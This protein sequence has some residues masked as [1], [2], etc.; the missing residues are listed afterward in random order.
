MQIDPIRGPVGESSVLHEDPR[1][2]DTPGESYTITGDGDLVYVQ[3][4][5]AHTSTYLR[6][7]P[8]WVEQMKRRV[9]E[10]NR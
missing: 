3:G 1:F 4:P 10:A 8:N 5:P 6:V 2:S 7:I 9:D